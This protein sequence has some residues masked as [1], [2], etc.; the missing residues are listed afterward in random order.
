MS[1]P[2]KW[3]YIPAIIFLALLLYTSVER[4]YIINHFPFDRV[5][6]IS[7]YM[8]NFYFLKAYGYHQVVP[9]WYNSQYVLFQFYPPMW[10]FLSYPLLLALGKVEL[11]TMVSI[12]LTFIAA[13][14]IAFWIGRNERFSRWQ[15]IGLFA[16][17]FA[18]P[19]V[20]SNFIRLGRPHELLAWVLFFGL[21]GVIMKYR[22][23]TITWNFLWVS[24]LY[25]SILL[26]HESVFL[27]SSIAFLSL[28]IIKSNQERIKIILTG[29]L[30][31]LLSMFWWLPFLRSLSGGDVFS[32]TY[33]FAKRLITFNKLY[34][35]ENVTSFIVGAAFLLA[36]YFYYKTHKEEKPQI[37]FLPQLIIG[38]LF[39]TRV[40]AFI[41]M[42]DRIYP[43][44][45]NMFLLVH[46]VYFIFKIDYLQ[47]SSFI[48]KAVPIALIILALVSALIFIKYIPRSVPHTLED[49]ETIALLPEVDGKVL[50]L[51][52]N[53]LPQAFYSYGA[54]YH[55]LSTPYGW[56]DPSVPA[57]YL[58]KVV[59]ADSFLHG[60]DCVSFNERLKLL[61][62]TNI[63]S[64]RENCS[65]LEAC[66][67]IE[68]DRR[69]LACLYVAK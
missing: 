19:F 58:Q 42:L 23:K 44:V 62:T 45:Y 24:I 22:S 36:F 7:S 63:I 14:L 61:N 16:L 56:S 8:G 69:S 48:R 2:R 20:A 1:I 4:S 18:N 31:G 34:L 28:L 68:K 66:G 41:P 29:L 32:M 6:D 51:G 11:A 3:L 38:I 13:L 10:Y 21:F 43:D 47:L 26:T 30:A 60:R 65:A 59:E 46:V 55:N 33:L 57:S 27:I 5:N 64:Y 35:V 40:V 37:F 49:E 39:F 12:Y 67:M 54:M 52:G 53:S 9:N 50:I 15:S 17:I 25:A